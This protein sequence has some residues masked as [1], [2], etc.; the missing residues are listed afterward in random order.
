MTATTNPPEDEQLYKFLKI[1][2]WQCFQS[3]KY[4]PRL[5]RLPGVIAALD[6]DAASKGQEM[7]YFPLAG[8]QSETLR[9]VLDLLLVDDRISNGSQ[10]ESREI[11]DKLLDYCRDIINNKENI[12]NHQDIDKEIGT[13]VQAFLNQVLMPEQ[14]WLVI[15]PINGLSLERKEGITISNQV[16]I[17]WFY[18]RIITDFAG[19]LAPN[20]QKR[21]EEDLVGKVCAFMF[22]MAIDGKRANEKARRKIDQIQ[23]ML[24]LHFGTDVFHSLPT[25]KLFKA[26]NKERMS[27]SR[28]IELQDEMCKITSGEQ[29]ELLKHMS[30]FSNFLDGRSVPKEISKDLLRAIRWFGS[31]VQAKDLEDKLVEYFFALETLLIPEEIGVKRER[32][33]FRWGLLYLRVKGELP[34]IIYAYELNRL[35]QKR[36]NIVHGGDIEK[37][38]VTIEDTRFLEKWTCEAIV[39][40]S[41]IVMSSQGAIS[42]V[43][44]LRDWI[45]L[46][47]REWGSNGND[48]QETNPP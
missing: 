21:L 37:E 27:V 10:K 16:I 47:R 14:E 7:T 26:I 28:P 3:D 33:V 11:Y 1:L 34:H 39:D 32:L 41:R 18:L 35:Y 44:E 17:N 20:D 13:R 24:R 6:K 4:T 38:P 46:D 43:Q 25:P 48:Q 31:A 22:V 45:E 12:R 5:D 19:N 29:D 23:H 36:S 15:S 9:K 40:I 30:I 42:N 8:G 2:G